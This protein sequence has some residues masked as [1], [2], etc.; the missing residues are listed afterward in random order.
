VLSKLIVEQVN[1]MFLGHISSNAS[2]IFLFLSLPIKHLQE[3][4]FVQG[5]R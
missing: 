3:I 2:F 5:R 1:M 4:A